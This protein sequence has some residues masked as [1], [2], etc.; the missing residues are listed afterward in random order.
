MR[1]SVV[2]PVL[3][4]AERISSCLELLQPM[5]RRGHEVIVVDGG[6]TDAT[7]SL[8]MP[9][10]TRVLRSRRGRAAQM[11]LGARFASGDTFVFLHV[12]SRLPDNAEQLLAGLLDGTPTDGKPGWGWFDVQLSGQS[13]VFRIVA[14]LMNSRARLSS[15]CTGDQALYVSSALFAEV[16]GFPDISLMED[17]AISRNLGTVAKPRPL[18]ARAIT[19]SRRWETRGVTRTILQM[20]RLR[21]LYFLGVSPDRLA[22]MY[23]PSLY[24]GG[25]P[26]HKYPRGRILVFARAPRAGEVKTRLAAVIGAEPAL[27]L[28]QAML[29]RAVETVES[30]ALAEFHLW[31]ASDPDHEE[32][33]RLCNAQ[34]IQLQQGADLGARMQHAAARELA[35]EGVEYVLIIGADCPAMEAEYLDR[36]FAALDAGMDV[37]LG[38]ARDGGYVLI[39]LRKAEAELFNNVDWGS[40]EVLRQTLAHIR[41]LGLSHQLLE[42]LW[43]VDDVEDLPLLEELRTPLPWSS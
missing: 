39:G 29:R 17:I 15:V 18:S 31:S 41:R 11:N 2:I 6:S 33:L 4:E 40:A 43:D 10:C 38:P 28:Y 24:T 1:L 37:V 9:L 32:F 42:P 20:W 8:A 27:R 19:S 26:R 21:L 5:R 23:Y 16:G 35:G 7:R 13:P 30:A 12:D 3:N 14:A 25:A 36:A 22:A 34:D